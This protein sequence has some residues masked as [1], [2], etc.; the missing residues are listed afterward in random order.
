MEG[1]TCPKPS[2]WYITVL[3]NLS[4]N[5]ISRLSKAQIIN[6]SWES[7][8]DF[9][10]VLMQL[11]LHL[12]LPRVISTDEWRQHSEHSLPLS[13]FLLFLPKAEGRA[14]P[15][16]TACPSLAPPDRDGGFDS[17]GVVV[18]SARCHC[19]ALRKGNAVGFLCRVLKRRPVEVMYVFT[20]SSISHILL[21]EYHS[22]LL[23]WSCVENCFVMKDLY[24]GTEQHLIKSMFVFCLTSPVLFSALS[25]DIQKPAPSIHS[26]ICT[27][28]CTYII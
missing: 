23:T 20:W 6:K 8:P 28:I 4:K 12:Q 11:P 14:F 15:V 25:W 13:S 7:K 24:W 22:N 16:L 17:H 19:L 27:Y 18:Q 9:R 1:T 2:F 21:S 3:W 26:Y 10:S 5:L